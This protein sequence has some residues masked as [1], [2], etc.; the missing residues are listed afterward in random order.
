M[1]L[2]LN[3]RSTEADA[4]R[5]YCFLSQAIALAYFLDDHGAQRVKD[6]LADAG[7][8]LDQWRNACEL[9]DLAPIEDHDEPREA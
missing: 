3:E 5:V 1:T 9:I 2:P 4:Q 8:T 7:L 6:L